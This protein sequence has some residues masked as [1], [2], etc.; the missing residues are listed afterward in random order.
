MLTVIARY[1]LLL[2]L[3]LSDT[4]YMKAEPLLLVWWRL[5]EPLSLLVRVRLA[6][7]L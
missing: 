1:L 3:L 5:V 2:S 7:P 4:L 6:E